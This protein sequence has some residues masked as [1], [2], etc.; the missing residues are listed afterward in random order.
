MTTEWSA[1]STCGRA[2][3]ARGPRDT[4]SKRRL[5]EATVMRLTAC[6]SGVASRCVDACG[7]PSREARLRARSWTSRT[8][9]CE[10]LPRRFRDINDRPVSTDSSA[11]HQSSALQ[12]PLIVVPRLGYQR[13]RT[14]ARRHAATP[15]L[16]E[17]SPPAAP[18][19][20]CSRWRKC[21]ASAR[22][23]SARLSPPAARPR[24]A[25]LAAAASA[26]T[27]GSPFGRPAAMPSS[28][29]ARLRLRP[30]MCASFGSLRSVTT[31]GRASP[32]SLCAGCAAGS[33]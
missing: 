18:R 1:T 9:L 31:P 14:P 12:R 11:G 21:R 32:R 28:I 15:M 27:R 19:A 23:R 10:G 3:R 2:K 5:A 22:L 4:R 25:R 17:H 13:G 26:A 29:H 20:S 6:H 8:T 7:H 16:S 30:S 24:H 33:P